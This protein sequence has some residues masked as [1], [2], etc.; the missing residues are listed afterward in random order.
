MQFGWSLCQ[1]ANSLGVSFALDTA[2]RFFLEC[3]IEQCLARQHCAVDGARAIRDATTY[4]GVAVSESP[5]RGGLRLADRVVL[6]VTQGQ[7]ADGI[8]QTDVGGEAK[9]DRRL[10]HV[11]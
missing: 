5:P 6:H 4:A 3:G 8:S 7:V 9:H 11:R 2:T 10:I 1:P